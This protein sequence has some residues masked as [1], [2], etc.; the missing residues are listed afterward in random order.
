MAAGSI[1]AV[2]EGG[3]GGGGGGGGGGKCATSADRTE[4]WG[5]AAPTPTVEAELQPIDS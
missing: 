1:S 5:M 4:R 2:A 3:I